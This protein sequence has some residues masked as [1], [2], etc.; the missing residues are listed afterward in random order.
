LNLQLYEVCEL[1]NGRKLTLVDY[2]IQFQEFIKDQLD[3]LDGKA[4]QEISSWFFEQT[5]T[6]FLQDEHKVE[7]LTHLYHS[8]QTGVTG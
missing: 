1:H 6:G 3:I 2:N 4:I 5:A 7:Q 8:F